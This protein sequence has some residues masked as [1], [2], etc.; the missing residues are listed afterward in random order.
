MIIR[1]S[2]HQPERK[3][4]H[5]KE[6]RVSRC[7]RASTG[8]KRNQ[9]RRH[10]SL[11]SKSTH[12]HTHLRMEVHDLVHG[13]A[14]VNVVKVHRGVDGVVLSP[15]ELLHCEAGRWVCLSVCVVED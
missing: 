8:P 13:N 14:E 5:S 10:H 1:N 4:G 3:R 2:A 9:N 7:C 11:V 12:T 6:R 15:G